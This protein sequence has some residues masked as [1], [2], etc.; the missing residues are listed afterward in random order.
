MQWARVELACSCVDA[1]RRRS[2]CEACWNTAGPKRFHSA[3][4]PARKMRRK[5]RAHLNQ[6]TRAF[7]QAGEV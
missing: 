5:G 3:T 7:G 1:S 6:Q 2:E 4:G